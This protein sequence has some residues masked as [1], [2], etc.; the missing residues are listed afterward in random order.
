MLSLADAR[1]FC[2]NFGA[3]RMNG[4]LIAFELW[5]LTKPA[6]KPSSEIHVKGEIDRCQQR[7]QLQ[8]V[9]EQ[10]L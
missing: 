9:Y 10:L 1:V 8:A 2:Y 3:G 6:T 5:N 4:Q 7:Q